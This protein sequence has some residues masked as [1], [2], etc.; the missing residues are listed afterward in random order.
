VVVGLPQEKKHLLPQ[1]FIIPH[2]TGTLIRGNKRRDSIIE[3]LSQRYPEI[4]SEKLE[5]CS[6]ACDEFSADV[7]LADNKASE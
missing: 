1:D 5:R 7:T 3:L 4:P 6:I 2:A